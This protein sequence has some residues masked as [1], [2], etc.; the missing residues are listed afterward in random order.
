[1]AISSEGT[2]L[3]HA[4]TPIGEVTS[5]KGP[6]Q[7]V[8]QID[9][10][11]L[12]DHARRY[13]GGIKDGG[14]VSFEMNLAPGDAGQNALRADFDGGLESAYTITLADGSVYGFNAIV[15]KLGGALKVD[16]AVSMSVTL[17]ISGAVTYS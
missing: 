11:A 9:V 13:I 4:G 6:E 14:E 5:I 15:T 17:K 1:M 3:A 16:D 10:T 2:I 7:S 12:E 8:K